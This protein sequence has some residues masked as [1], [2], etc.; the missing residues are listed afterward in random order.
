MT[1]HH[2]PMAPGEIRTAT[3]KG[4]TFSLYHVCGGSFTHVSVRM[5]D[6]PSVYSKNHRFE[7]DAVAD[8]ARQVEKA[9]KED[10]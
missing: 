7:S 5:V 1:N 2:K 3:V 8:Y 9:L 4:F 10:Q 6:G